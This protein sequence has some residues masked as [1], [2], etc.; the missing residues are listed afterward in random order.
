MDTAVSQE[1]LREILKILI[2]KQKKFPKSQYDWLFSNLDP[3]LDYAFSQ[4]ISKNK[5]VLEI[6]YSLLDQDSTDKINAKSHFRTENQA[7]LE[8]QFQELSR[9]FDN[10]LKMQQQESNPGV[11][12]KPV[13]H[14][15]PVPLE[16][17]LVFVLM[18][19]SESW[20]HYLW[21]EEIQKTVQQF[22]NG[23]LR[24]I[25]ADDLFGHDIMIDI[26]ESIA[27][28][29]IIIADITNRN[30]NVF[31]ELGIAHCLGKDVILLSQSTEHIPFDLLRFRHCIY[32]NDGYGHIKLREYI[33]NAIE[34]ILRND[35]KKNVLDSNETRE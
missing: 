13:F 18:P 8:V 2:I 27:K 21:Q 35:N 23:K 24:C 9:K 4:A 16:K 22:M 25:R 7:D 19:F 33:K 34:I 26:Y 15:R 17:D 32:T 11:W 1:E 28:A 29:R 5:N 31:Y 3:L 12:V 10:I 6:V 30:A 20:S 14:I